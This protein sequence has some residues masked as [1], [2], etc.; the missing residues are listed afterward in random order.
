M[1]KS[2]DEKELGFSS[3]SKY[4]TDNS[5]ISYI[6]EGNVIEGKYHGMLNAEEGL[7]VRLELPE[8]YFVGA[9]N[10][11]DFIMLVALVLPIIFTIICFRSWKKFG[12]DEKVI[13]T[14]EFYPPEGLNSA[15]IGFLYKGRAESK[16]VVSLLIYLANKGYIK[17]S[18]RRKSILF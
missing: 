14:V 7:T 18:E 9:S 8:G 3:G 15:E 17:I 6:V 16:D 12:K 1:P 5:N 4:S 2:F 13:E 10:N 11:F